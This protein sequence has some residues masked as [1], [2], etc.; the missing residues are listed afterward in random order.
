MNLTVRAM[1]YKSGVAGPFCSAL[2]FAVLLGEAEWKSH[3]SAP[4]RGPQ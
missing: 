4:S 2:P 1:G 3:T